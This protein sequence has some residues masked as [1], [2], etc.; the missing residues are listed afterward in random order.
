MKSTD[1]STNKGEIEE[2]FRA[3]NAFTFYE[4]VYATFEHGQWWVSALPRGAGG[5]QVFAV[6]DA[7]GPPDRV[8]SGL[9]FEET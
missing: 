3:L 9:S 2:A 1:P 7:S 6:V 8:C 4:D 5:W